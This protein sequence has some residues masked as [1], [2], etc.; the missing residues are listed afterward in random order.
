MISMYLGA[1]NI[2]LNQAQK[3]AFRETLRMIGPSSHPQ[4]AELMHWRTRLDGD[5]VLMRSSFQESDLTT[6]GLRQLLAT[7]LHVP[8]AQIAA[9][10]SSV[11]YK[12][13]PS[14]ILT[15][16]NNAVPCMRFILFAGSRATAQQSNDEAVSYLKLNAAAWGDV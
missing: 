11:T 5:A 13:T 14:T 7:A 10:Q 1:E 2:A 8:L 16:S 12:I 4:P 9:A 3:D 6:N 15:M